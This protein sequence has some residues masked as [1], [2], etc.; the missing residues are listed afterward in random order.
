M[1]K[2][3][4]TVDYYTCDF[5]CGHKADVKWKIETHEDNCFCNPRNRACRIC[6]NCEIKD[7]FMICNHFNLQLDGKDKAIYSL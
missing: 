1:S 6:S 4:R 2:L 5:K 3:V 7:G